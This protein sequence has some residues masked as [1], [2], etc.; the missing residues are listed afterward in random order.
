M[1]IRRITFS[2]AAVIAVGAMAESAKADQQQKRQP[3]VE[4]DSYSGPPFMRNIPGLRIF[5]GDYALTDEEFDELYGTGRRVYRDDRD[6]DKEPVQPKRRA[7]RKEEQKPAKKT[8]SR[9]ASQ[10]G[11]SPGRKNRSETKTAAKPP[12][13]GLTCEK[14][15]SV[16]SSYGFSSVTPS[17]CSG[18]VYAFSAQRDGKNFSIRLNPANG[19][20]TEVKK[21]P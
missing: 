13:P 10:D 9:P 21:L 16:V 17:S 6:Y 12:V 14:A 1:F 3:A 20:L 2:L 11:A 4:H 7:I 8:A 5:F 15:T 19:E 18:K